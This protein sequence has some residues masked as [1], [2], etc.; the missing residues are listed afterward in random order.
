M[1]RKIN[2]NMVNNGDYNHII[3][4]FGTRKS[5]IQNE[6]LNLFWVLEIENKS[7]KFI[8]EIKKRPT[9]VDGPISQSDPTR[10]CPRQPTSSLPR[11]PTIFTY[12]WAANV[13]HPLPHL[14]NIPLADVVGPDWQSH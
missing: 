13:I 6:N 9:S 2:N 12:T 7:E 8:K 1:T 11:A 14:G 5:K 3:T 10:L 4:N